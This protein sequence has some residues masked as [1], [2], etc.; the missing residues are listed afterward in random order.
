MERLQKVIAQAGIA[1]RRAAEELIVAGRVSVNDK[2]ITE[3]GFKVTRNDII[4][5][6]G[7]IIEKEEKVYLLMNK[8]RNIITSTDDELNRPTVISILPERYRGYRLFPVGRLD[9]DTKGALLLTN[10]GEMMNKLV[11]PKSNVEKEYLVRVDGLFNKPALR[12]LESGVV[13]DGYK[14]RPAKLKL[15]SVDRKN[16]SSLVSII[17][18]EGKYHQVKKMFA[19]VGFPVKRITRIRFGNLTLEGLSEGEVR[20]LKTHEVK[21]LYVLSEQ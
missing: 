10:D 7:I 8:P 20:E 2:I 12:K 17:I 13:I 9:Y 1:S 16:K 14:T 4:K 15:V 19:A 5:V 18:K 11:G 21:Q 3:L 6:D